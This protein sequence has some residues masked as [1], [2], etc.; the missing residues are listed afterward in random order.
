MGK[1]S[2]TIYPHQD[3]LRMSVAQLSYQPWSVHGCRQTLPT[4]AD[5][6]GLSTDAGRPYLQMLIAMFIAI[7][8]LLFP[9]IL[10]VE[11]L[12][13]LVFSC[14]VLQAHS[15]L[16]R[17]PPSNTKLRRGVTLG[18]TSDHFLMLYPG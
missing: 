4:D 16:H 10:Q 5:C 12:L 2:S 6:H 9:S 8:L 7:S 1:G 11:E 18:L 15:H 17:W 14:W 13:S 3:L